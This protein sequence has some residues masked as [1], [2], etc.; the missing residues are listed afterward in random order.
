M[1]FLGNVERSNGTFLKTQLVLLHLGAIL[2]SGLARFIA[3]IV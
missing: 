1:T 3:T 2:Q